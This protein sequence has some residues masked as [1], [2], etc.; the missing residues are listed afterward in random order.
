MSL[1]LGQHRDITTHYRAI[2][3]LGSCRIVKDDG[4]EG[5]NIGDIDLVITVYI[6]NRRCVT[7][8]NHVDERVDISKSHLTVTV[9]VTLDSSIGNE[10]RQRHCQY[11]G[12]KLN[13]S[14]HENSFTYSKSCQSRYSHH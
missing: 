4:N 6:G 11:R 1:I 3:G 2:I 13:S 10:R 7:G 14:V 12:I 8:Q 5:V 9:H